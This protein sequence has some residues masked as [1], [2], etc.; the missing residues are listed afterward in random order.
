MK[1]FSNIEILLFMIMFGVISIAI[2]IGSAASSL[3]DIKETLDV[4][5]KK[6]TDYDSDYEFDSRRDLD[7]YPAPSKLTSIIKLLNAILNSS[8]TKKRK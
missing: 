1:D 6:I 2:A 3:K 8:Q 4:I 7:S 5:N